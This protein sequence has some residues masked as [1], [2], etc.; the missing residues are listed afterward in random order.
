MIMGFIDILNKIEKLYVEHAPA[1][2]LRDN[3]GLLKDEYSALERKVSVLKQKIQALESE[4][5]ELKMKIEHLELDIEN[6][7]KEINRLNEIINASEK[8]KSIKQLSEIENQILKFFC[9]A[10][11]E[12]TLEK[13]AQSL[14][15]DIQVVQY[16]IENFLNLGFLEL[17]KAE[18]NWI[19]KERAKYCIK[20][21]GRAYII[22]NN[23]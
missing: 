23:I 15:I 6:K 17:T 7:N 22:E 20:Q 2:I 13:V 1:G 12:I 9:D 10:N 16:H 19:P 21:K 14:S 5:S 4:N 11:Q 3:I 8:N 18:T